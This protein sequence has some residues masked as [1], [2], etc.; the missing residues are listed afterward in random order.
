M[1][2]ILDYVSTVMDCRQEKKVL[3]KMI[4]VGS[5]PISLN[6]KRFAIGTNPEKHLERIMNL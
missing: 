6:K 3:H 4:D 5:K 1:K 2:T